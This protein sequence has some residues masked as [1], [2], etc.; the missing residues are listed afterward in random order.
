M[1]T[2][3]LVIELDLPDDENSWAI[4]ISRSYLDSRSGVDRQM[5]VRRSS[6]DRIIC[7]PEP[8][9]DNFVLSVREE[10]REQ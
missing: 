3:I 4:S 7:I 2:K 9:P 6:Q 1:R 8:G 5:L 10:T